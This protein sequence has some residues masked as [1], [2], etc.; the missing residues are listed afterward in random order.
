MQN[1]VTVPVIRT[2]LHLARREFVLLVYPRVD[3]KSK[4]AK[5]A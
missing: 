2:N 4:N 1:P 3:K 5:I